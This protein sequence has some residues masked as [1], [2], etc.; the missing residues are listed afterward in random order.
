[1]V[2][3]IYSATAIETP[4]PKLKTRLA[5]INKGKRGAFPSFSGSALSFGGF[6]SGHSIPQLF[7]HGPPSIQYSRPPQYT[8]SIVNIG[9]WK[10]IFLNSK[11]LPKF[12]GQN[13][14][15]V[16]FSTGPPSAGH[17]GFA[18]SSAQVGG[19][20]GSQLGGYSGSS[21]H[22]SFGG[23][24]GGSSAFTGAGSYEG[25]GQSYVPSKLQSH[26][27]LG[28]SYVPSKL[29][30][31]VQSNYQPSQPGLSQFS[32]LSLSLPAT[33]YGIPSH[34]TKGDK[35]LFTPNQDHYQMAW[36]VPGGSNG[37]PDTLFMTGETYTAA[38]V[39]QGN[40]GGIPTI[41]LV[42][43]NHGGSYGGSFVSGGISSSLEVPPSKNPPLNFNGPPTASQ[44]ETKE[45][46]QE[47][48][49]NYG[50]PEYPSSQPSSY[51]PP[52]SGSLAGLSLSQASAE[53]QSPSNSYGPPSSGP[54]VIYDVQSSQEGPHSEQAPSFAAL[55]AE[56]PAHYQQ[57]ATPQVEYG[58]PSSGQQYQQAS[59]PNNHASSYQDLSPPSASYG[60]PSVGSSSSAN[61]AASYQE[62]PAS[63]YGTPSGSYGNP[64][65]SHASVSYQEISIPTKPS[66]SYGSPSSVPSGS[67]GTPSSSSHGS[68]VSYQEVSIPSS[69][70]QSSSQNH[71]SYQELSISA[72]LYGT[73]SN[74]ASY[75]ESYGS[76]KPS[77]PSSSYEELSLPSGSYG[78]QNHQGSSLSNYQ[79]LST[80]S[81]SYG[82]PSSSSSQVSSGYQVSS[83]SFGGSNYQQLPSQQIA[84]SFETN[85]SPS[86]AYGTPKQ[87]VPSGSYGSPSKP[88][89]QTQGG[90][91]ASFGSSKPPKVANSYGPPKD[92]LPPAASSYES[93]A[94]GTVY[95][96][97]KYSSPSQSKGY[98]P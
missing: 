78:T 9:D 55:V 12:Q 18:S 22:G 57:L 79:E 68:S 69:G 93:A 81:V 89:Y 28:Q 59:I 66:A 37:A 51:L 65:S 48:S 5:P 4:K 54:S 24:S 42:G 3:V 14:G 2:A 94:S 74:Q 47:V 82:A 77:A 92:Y 6:A 75:Q 26:E 10:S 85:H 19:Y 63:S 1:M 45:Q 41:S 67:Y 62:V 43:E 64:T 27:G 72:G 40:H 50:P 31:P 95:N 16:T 38:Q 86:S 90:F 36:L 76:P 88:T 35:P 73:P 8:Q 52:P 53:Y 29:Q 44:Y 46:V 17:G 56:P 96:T 84:T 49:Q 20:S 7:S 80:P 33:T 71:A 25:L 13:V 60:T 61:H 39:A 91:S 30:A 11:G 34:S 70:S 87:S 15:P 97:I 21:G 83:G 58:S 23:Y 32:K 98:E